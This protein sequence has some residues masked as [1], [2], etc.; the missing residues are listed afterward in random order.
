LLRVFDR[1]RTKPF[2]LSTAADRE[3]DMAEG[4]S[5]SNTFLGFILGGVVVVVAVIAFLMYSG[6]YF[7]QQKSTSTIKIE[8]PKTSTK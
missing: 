6:G 3:Q 5:G 4:N 2:A 8:L 7:G 1:N